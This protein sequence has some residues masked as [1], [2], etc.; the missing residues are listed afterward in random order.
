MYLH[1]TSKK[2]FLTLGATSL[3]CSRLFFFLINDQEGPN[4][5]IV[6]VLAGVIYLISLTAYTA[7]FSKNTPLK[8]NLLAILIQVLLVATLYFFL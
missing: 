8:K 2:V 7:K 6:V 3:I 5:L 1:N 4:L